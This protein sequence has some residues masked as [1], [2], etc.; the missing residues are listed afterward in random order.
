MST[1]QTNKT[2]AAYTPAIL[3]QPGQ[4]PR[5]CSVQATR[6]DTPEQ[7]RAKLAQGKAA[8]VRVEDAR[9]VGADGETV[10]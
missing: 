1:W 4:P 5:K 2:S 3:L 9:E 10:S 7:A 6:L 8:W